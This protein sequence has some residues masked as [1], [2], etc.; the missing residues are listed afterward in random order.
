MAIE[1]V[2]PDHQPPP[3][4]CFLASFNLTTTYSYNIYSTAKQTMLLPT[5][6]TTISIELS[7]NPFVR[8]LKEN[9]KLWWRQRVAKRKTNSK[10]WTLRFN[11]CNIW[12][13]TW[14]SIIFWLSIFS[15]LLAQVH[16]LT[17]VSFSWTEKLW[18]TV[19]KIEPN[20]RDPPVSALTNG[21]KWKGKGANFTDTTT[22][23]SVPHFFFTNKIDITKRSLLPYIAFLT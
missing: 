1:Y 19:Q 9:G 6:L 8:S 18:S 23:W 15:L 12:K 16:Y 10:V 13:K 14:V 4:W 11:S 17:R 22:N 21:C 2:H 5:E 3:S 7:C 20:R